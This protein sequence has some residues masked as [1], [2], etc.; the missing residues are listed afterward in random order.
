MSEN[1]IERVARETYEKFRRRSIERSPS[2]E[3]WIDPWHKVDRMVRDDQ[4]E[5]AKRVIAA[6]LEPTEAMLDAGW[7]AYGERGKVADI[8]QAMVKAA[9][10]EGQ[11]AGNA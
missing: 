9:L 10:S 4:R 1:M 3:K 11:E 8:W 2:N 6:M 7:R 5:N